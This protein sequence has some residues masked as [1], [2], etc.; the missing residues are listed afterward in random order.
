MHQIFLIHSFVDGHLGCFHVLAILN[1]SALNRGV[2][3]FFELQFCLN[4]FWG[5]GLLTLMVILFLVFWGTSYTVSCSG[6]SNLHSHQQYRRVPF[7]T[8]SL[9]HLLFLE[10]LMMAILTDVRWYLIVVL[11]YISL[12]INDVEHFLHLS[13]GHQY[14]FFGEMSV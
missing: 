4:I 11:I 8:Y 1:S 6:C 12:M 5:V 7:S 14:V 13:I 2:H 3:V 10:F 9:Q